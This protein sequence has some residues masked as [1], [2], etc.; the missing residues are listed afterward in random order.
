MTTGKFIFKAT[1]LIA[2]FILMS[3]VLGQVRESVIA[4]LLGTTYL[5]DAYQIAMKAPNMLFAIISGALATVIVPVFT[6]Y[7]SRGEKSEAWKLFNTVMVLVFF[8]FLFASVIGIAAAPIL[9]KLVAPGFS[10]LTRDLTIEL[11][12]IILPW[13]VFA[14]L[15]SLFTQ[16]LNANNIFGIPAFSTSVNNVFIIVFALTLGKIYGVYGLALGTTLAMA[17]MALVQFPVL[18][19][20]GFRINLRLDLRHPGL[21]KIWVLALPSLFSLSV[22]QANV[23]VTFV[24]ASWLVVGSVSSLG[25]AYRLYLLP[26]DLLV[27]AL[28]TAVFPTI[29]RLAAEVEMESF[30][31]TLLS[32]LKVVFVGIIPAS[33]LFITLSHPI[34]NFVYGWGVF[35]EKAAAMTSAALIFYSVGTVGY[36]SAYLLVRGF[37]S[38]QDTRTPLKLSIVQVLINLGLS[39]LL[40]GPLQHA[41]LALASSLSNLAYMVLLMWY[42]GKKVPGLYQGGL[43]KFIPAVIT[44][45]SLMA[46]VCYVVSGELAG[47]VHGKISLIIQIGLSGM[48]G[49]GVFVAALFAM[50]LEEAHVLWRAFKKALAGRRA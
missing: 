40:I 21:R 34:V 16:L 15:A 13:M 12:R 26:V 18:C 4:S 19:K 9:V 20:T 46:V 11:S 43:L 8:F 42:L 39:L 31:A 27:T 38:L 35:D 36:A 28:T 2:F 24:L 37:Y 14:A 47:Q 41:G 44:A 17:A 6:D 5:A 32:S 49:L 1:L 29:S 48:A 22:I 10:G 25:Y 50:R 3:K 30:A 33:M 45:A 23:F 7:V